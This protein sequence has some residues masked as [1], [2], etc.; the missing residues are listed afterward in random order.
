DTPESIYHEIERLSPRPSPNIQLTSNTRQGPAP[1]PAG[2]NLAN[3]SKA[4]Q[5]VAEARALQQQDRLVEA[6]DK[7]AE[8]QRLGVA[9]RADEDNPNLLYQQT[10]FLAR[11]RIDGLVHHAGEIIR[12]GTQAPA[13]RCQQAEKDLGQARQLAA[14]FG[15][16]MQ[17]IER[18]LLMVNQ[19]RNG[20]GV[21]L[22]GA[23]PTPGGMLPAPSID[24]GRTGAGPT[25]PS[26]GPASPPVGM[27]SEALQKLDQ[28]RLELSKGETTLAR[29]LAEEAINGGA[30]EQGL[31]VLRSIDAEERGQQA[32]SANRAFEAVVAAY[33]R[34][35]YRQASLMLAAIDTKSLSPRNQVRLREILNTAE[36]Q[37]PGGRGSAIALTG[38]RDTQTPGGKEPDLNPQTTLP[39]K[40]PGDAGRAR[41]TDDAQPSML[42]RTKAIREVKFQQLRD[43]GMKVQS[44]ALERF[45]SGQTEEAVAML[46]DYLGQLAEEQLDPGQLTLLR[47]PIESRVQQFRLMKAQ[48]DFANNSNASLRESKDRR[49]RA[50]NAEQVKQK[51][52]A[53]LM[54]QYNELFR[55]GKYDEAEAL[56]MRVKELD[57]DNPMATA[58]VTMA[59]MQRNKDTY[60]RNKQTKE[61][62][63]EN[64]MNDTDDIGPEN[65]VRDGV[66]FE[67][68]PERRRRI[69]NRKSLDE[70]ET[71]PMPRKTTSEKNIE[72][73]LTSPVTVSF[74]NAPLRDVIEYIRADQALNVYVDEPALAEKGINQDLPVTIKLENIALKSALNLLLHSVHLTYVVGDDVLKITTEDH[75]RGK[76]EQRVLQVT[77]LVLAV[78]NFGTV[79]VT[80]ASDLGMEAIN[81]PVV[82]SPSPVTGPYSLN[83]GQQVGTPA[84]PG[85]MANGGSGF[86]SEAGSGG[87]VKVS[88]SRAQTHED[89]LIKLIT[90][91]VAPRSWAEQGG[92][93]SID[94]HPMTMSLVINQTPD[95]QDQ[96]ADLLAALRR[97]Q[98]Q[99][100]AVEV[101]FISIAEDFFERIGVNFNMNIIN[102]RGSTLQAQPL[103][104]S[105]NFMP[106]GFINQFAP[107]NFL[108]GLTP[109]GTLTSDLNIPITQNTYGPAIPPFGGYPGVPGFG[110]LTMGLAFL[111]DIQV[112]LFM[113]A[114]QGD[115][116]SNVMQAPKLTLFN[117]QTGNIQ[118]Q[119]FQFFVVG[120]QVIPQLGQ[121]T[122]FPQTTLFPLGVQLTI[123]AVISADR[124]FV[125]LSMTPSMSNV[126]NGEVNLFP[127]V[128]PIFPLFDGTATGQPVVFTQ[129]VQQ[130]RLTRV[131]VQT[132]VAVPDGGT[133]LMGGLKRLSEGRNE[134]GP[135]ILSKIPYL[136]RLFRNTAYGRSAESLLIMVTPRVIIQAEEEEKQ[137]GYTPPPQ[138]V[139]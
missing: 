132:T 80:P 19:L 90:N 33:H 49:L 58:A 122:Y 87:N 32:L 116:R 8:A 129:F 104:T 42:E 54:K 74:V 70:L 136:N 69:H 106:P 39:T 5:L 102:K 71:L 123:Q 10:A 68:D 131:S 52:V 18:T 44:D 16:D 3:Q 77:D 65:V 66:S 113:E 24:Q 31:A 67:K 120:V 11:Q 108:S 48:V 59:R 94:Y 47:R 36:M 97:L 118:V 75:A 29:R 84:G 41:A 15:Q 93:G 6:R 14:A 73:K 124:R 82:G 46:Q 55:L 88:K 117:G 112:F 57:P 79:G 22:V 4:R 28:A 1:T 37:Q 13:V 114:V 134:F 72:R 27:P 95:I 138:V 20:G 86:A 38:A 81:Q 126:V 128:T 107:G 53:D 100:V 135:P 76:L 21:T 101:K 127:V 26:V 51:S 91:T 9:F 23:P 125:R 109:A 60:Q 62:A 133:V 7:I 85:S 78:E 63:F 103:L 89:M 115:I 111:S 30:R 17:P 64:I 56:A 139:P 2:E 34:R 105:G 40:I 130:P 45:R 25:G 110:G 43:Q 83:S 121:F 61:D 92:P 99:E 96:V 50:Q 119:D 98:D 12:Y 137:T 35:E